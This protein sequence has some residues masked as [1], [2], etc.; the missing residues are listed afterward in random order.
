MKPILCFSLFCAVGLWA[1]EAQDRAAIDKT[2]AAINDPVQRAG[3]LTR[4]ADS[5][6]D[7]DRLVELHRNIM[8][9]WQ[10]SLSLG[11]LIGMNEPWTELTVP[12]LVSGRIRFLTP[13]VAI[14]DGA[15]TIRGA[16]TLTPSVPL[17]FVMKKEG[18]GWLISAVRVLAAHAIV[19][20]GRVR[21]LPLGN[22]ITPQGLKNKA[23]TVTA[24]PRINTALVW[25]KDTGGYSTNILQI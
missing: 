23:V 8:R 25:R 22:A 14:V 16:V 6:V 5:S 1:D 12:R 9:D 11:V 7:F 4:D 24:L 15:S 13:S 21:P 19:P 3:L 20:R 18:A 17:L 10:D 2:I